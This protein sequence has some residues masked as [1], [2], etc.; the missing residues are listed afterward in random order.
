MYNEFKGTH[1]LSIYRDEVHRTRNNMTTSCSTSSSISNAVINNSFVSGFTRL[2]DLATQLSFRSQ[3]E[4]LQ[5]KC[6]IIE[7]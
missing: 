1:E 6:E 5:K 2:T 3:K 7:E 4:A